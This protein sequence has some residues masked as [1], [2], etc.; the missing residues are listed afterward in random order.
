M[1][2]RAQDKRGGVGKEGASGQLKL[3]K[4]H[5]GACVTSKHLYVQKPGG[6]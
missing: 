2:R 5:G 1:E 6:C 4:D 3:G